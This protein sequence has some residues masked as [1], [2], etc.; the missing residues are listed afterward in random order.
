MPYMRLL[1]SKMRQPK[2]KLMKD[3]STQNFGFFKLY[4]F[5]YRVFFE[6]LH[7]DSNRH[8]YAFKNIT[9][10]HD[11]KRIRVLLQ[12]NERLW[13]LIYD[14]VMQRFIANI[15]DTCSRHT[16]NT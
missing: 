12:L 8:I 6:I 15:F 4:I 5:V 13:S 1:E 2:K 3:I 11:N 10:F 9:K 16:D 14:V 7:F